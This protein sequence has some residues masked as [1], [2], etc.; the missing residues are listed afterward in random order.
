LFALSTLVLTAPAGAQ[1]DPLAN[2]PDPLATLNQPYAVI[3]AEDRAEE[4]LLPAIAAMDD[5]P[6]VLGDPSMAALITSE[7]P[8]FAALALWAEGT[9]QQA[10]LDALRSVT[11]RGSRFLFSLPYGDSAVDDALRSTGLTPRLTDGKWLAG[12]SFP[13]L[14]GLDW[15]VA[16]AIVEAEQRAAEGDGAGATDNLLR[17]IRL[18]RLLCDRS[19]QGEVAW[20]LETMTIGMQSLR[21]LVYRYTSAFGEQ[22]LIDTI[23][24]LDEDRLLMRRVALPTGE[25]LAALQ[26]VKGTFDRFGSPNPASFGATMA[27]V[28]AGDRPLLRFGKADW[29]RRVGEGH[30]GYYDTVDEINAVYNDWRLRWNVSVDWDDP[31]RTQPTEYELL[32]R[33][34][35]AMILDVVPDLQTIADLYWD[36]SIEQGGTRSALGAMGYYIRS[37]AFP[38]PLF[39]I[40]PRYV[41]QLD[42]DPW[43]PSGNEPFSYFVPIRDQPRGEREAPKP[44]RVTI[45]LTESTG[46]S[47]IPALQ[48][49]AEREISRKWAG[50]PENA[51]T[52]ITQDL[53]RAFSTFSTNGPTA[54]TDAN[55]LAAPII[56]TLVTSAAELI[57]P[58]PQPNQIP[59]LR[60]R[61]GEL[62]SDEA[63]YQKVAKAI[64]SGN[65]FEEDSARS[66]YIALGRAAARAIGEQAG[67]PEEFSPDAEDAVVIDLDD[68][69]FVLY[70][71][72]QDQ[73]MG[74]A[75]LVG[76]GG[77]DILLWPP[78]LSLTRDRLLE[79][80]G[81]E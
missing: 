29:W 64:A 32:D 16:L 17:V 61:A 78:L 26:L 5:A 69:V 43:D 80:A 47:T 31:L 35:F 58:A 62:V 6:D 76:P 45:V 41:A 10:A 60:V 8:D 36:L 79:S 67:L 14:E 2:F 65:R 39:A 4:V 30:A 20:G 13:H 55:S 24:A 81:A 56:E 50:L 9:A 68:S 54:L 22:T 53:A 12:T 3:S 75:R 25:R 28:D 48:R 72:G 46:V 66:L 15:L 44:H 51:K 71:I 74:W 18:G 70:S 49:E 23:A 34:R 11:E 27:A 42:I 33:S 19:F 57:G 63:E 77:D 1:V 73:T 59:P 21:D 7:N 40:R 37:G 52:R 38:R